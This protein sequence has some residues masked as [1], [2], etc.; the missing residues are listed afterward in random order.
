MASSSKKATT[1][2]T[3]GTGGT[4]TGQRKRRTA[5]KSQPGAARVLVPI[6]LAAAGIFVFVMQLNAAWTGVVGSFLHD[7][8]LGLFGCGF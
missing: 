4:K 1:K 2:Q 5:G 6:F 8:F 7:M 3:R